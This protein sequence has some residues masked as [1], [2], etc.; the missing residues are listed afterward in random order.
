[1]YR[2]ADA[3]KPLAIWMNGGPGSSSIFGNFLENGPMTITSTGTTVDG[4]TTYTYEMGL[5]LEGDWE[6][7]GTGSWADSAHLV[8]VDQPEGT[9]FSYSTVENDYL[10]TMEETAT[11]F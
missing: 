5:R 2:N 1:M 10:T 8:F 7:A 4:E 9:G 3:T 11:E 6:G